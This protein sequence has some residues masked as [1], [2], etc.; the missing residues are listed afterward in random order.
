MR[1]IVL[2]IIFV[3]PA[4]ISFGE[5]EPAN[6]VGSVP[7]SFRE[8]YYDKAFSD[9]KLNRD[10]K[11]GETND[12]RYYYYCSQYF[13]KELI[14]SGDVIYGDPLSTSLQIEAD[15]IRS[16][17]NLKIT[18]R[19]Y[20]IRSSEAN[21]FAT[22]PGAI[23]VTTGLVAH[24]A[25]IYELLYVLCH[26]IAH[27]EKDHLYTE[28]VEF[29]ELQFDRS[30]INLRN[31]ISNYFLHSREAEF[32]ADSLGYIYFEALKYPR[33]ASIRALERLDSSDAFLFYNV[34]F[35]TTLSLNHEF[36]NL[37]ISRGDLMSYVGSSDS[38]L[39]THPEFSKR[40]AKIN[41]MSKEYDEHPIGAESHFSSFK[42]TGINESLYSDYLKGDFY[43]ILAY[44]YISDRA[45]SDSSFIDYLHARSLYALLKL[46]QA[47]ST[48]RN[49]RDASVLVIESMGPLGH[50]V[51]LLEAPGSQ[52][53]ERPFAQ[54]FKKITL[55]K[56]WSKTATSLIKVH[57]K[58]SYFQRPMIFDDCV[59]IYKMLQLD[60]VTDHTDSANYAGLFFQLKA[61][62]AELNCKFDITKS[63]SA[64]LILPYETLSPLTILEQS[65]VNYDFFDSLILDRFLITSKKHGL[66]QEF[67]SPENISSSEDLNLYTDLTRILRIREEF[68]ICS[69]YAC[70]LPEAQLHG[71]SKLT[72][73]RLYNEN[74]LMCLEAKEYDLV[75]G[76][77]E[78]TAH[79]DM[80]GSH[81]GTSK[82]AL[83]IKEY[84]KGQFKQKK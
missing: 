34:C 4:Y 61:C 32:E 18:P 17:C 26:E 20:L 50:I 77:F 49:K 31:L 60:T 33:N 81:I 28:L 14:L 55:A 35:D 21:A 43:K 53:V 83:L 72:Q 3:I 42:V 25:S 76:T 74:S 7:Y 29:H 16:A 1:R 80:P 67:F 38:F 48:E 62:S 63:K 65:R 79:I 52:G 10:R 64:M 8:S 12:A 6:C 58:S 23:F 40:I 30:M 75:K 15:K 84:Y 24:S 54:Y 46:K 70:P 11:Y 2:A 9:F 44:Y 57:E 56:L 51:E 5:Y 59:N 19:V 78:I 27:V 68:A 71:Y 37:T 13:L 22:Q 39:R 41:G 47:I 73:V 66:D 45:Y 82:M 69:R 36:P